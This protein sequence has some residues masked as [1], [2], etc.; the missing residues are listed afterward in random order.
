MLRFRKLAN[1]VKRYTD[2]SIEEMGDNKYAIKIIYFIDTGNTIADAD[3][4]Y[5]Q[6]IICNSEEK[7]KAEELRIE[8]N[9]VKTRKRLEKAFIEIGA[10]PKNTA[11]MVREKM[12]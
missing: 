6:D 5:T 8:K 1:P 12:R 2:Y 9:I 3:K 7:F 4:K 10:S 11:L